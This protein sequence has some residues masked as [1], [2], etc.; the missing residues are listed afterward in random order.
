MEKNK[1]GSKVVYD[2]VKKEISKKVN[3]QSKMANA[4]FEVTALITK[5]IGEK[6]K[7]ALEAFEVDDYL[8]SDIIKAC[9]SG[10]R[11]GGDKTVI[12]GV[13]IQIEWEVV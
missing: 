7:A 5:D 11:K 12:D 8:K 2:E 4:E 1:I 13:K 6:E 9:Q 3:F 10:V